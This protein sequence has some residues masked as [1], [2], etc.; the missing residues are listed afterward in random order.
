MASQ[1]C[2][3][4]Y[5]IEWPNNPCVHAP[6]VEGVG[7]LVKHTTGPVSHA[8]QCQ[9][10]ETLRQSEVADMSYFKHM[11]LGIY[12][13]EQ[14]FALTKEENDEIFFQADE[15]DIMDPASEFEELYHAVPQDD[16]L[17]HC[18]Y[19]GQHNCAHKP[20]ENM[21]NYE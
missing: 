14:D 7:A 1:R 5:Y 9:K 12:Y 11:H 16:G 13:P 20:A 3:Q 6:R 8:S 18:P 21:C 2:E 17:Y 15:M 10:Q 19:E 4:S